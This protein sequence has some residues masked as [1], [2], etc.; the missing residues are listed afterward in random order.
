MNAPERHG[1]FVDIEQHA[2]VPATLLIQSRKEAVE[3][4]E[5]AIPSSF[6]PIPLSQLADGPEE[7]KLSEIYK[8]VGVKS[9]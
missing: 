2:P 9:Y 4:G 1:A 3:I 6:G 8:Y 5:Q 7:D